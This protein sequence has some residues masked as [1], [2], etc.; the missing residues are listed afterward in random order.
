[1]VV[2]EPTWGMFHQLACKTML[3]LYYPNFKYVVTLYITLLSRMWICSISRA[4]APGPRNVSGNI[5][6]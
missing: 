3:L 5:L 4:M 2:F 6:P 1:M